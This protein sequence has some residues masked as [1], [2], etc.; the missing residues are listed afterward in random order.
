MYFIVFQGPRSRSYLQG[1]S[2]G[3]KQNRNSVKKAKTLPDTH[4]LSCRDQYN[5]A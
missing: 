5:G 1:N 4:Q 3:T 2:E